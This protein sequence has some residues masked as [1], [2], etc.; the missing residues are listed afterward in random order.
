VKIADFGLAQLAAA[1]EHTRLTA[2]NVAVGS[3]NYMAPEQLL[4][5]PVDL[6]TD[7][8][9]L[10]ASA[11]HMLTGKPPHAGKAVSQIMA[12]RLSGQS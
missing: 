12:Q 1:D 11:F 10:G 5:N 7:I 9:A 8:F 3:P 2:P 4:G 6:R